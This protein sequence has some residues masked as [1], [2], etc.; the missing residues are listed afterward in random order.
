MAWIEGSSDGFD[1]SGISASRTSANFRLGSLLV[2]VRHDAREQVPQVMLEA[3][4]R[5]PS[6]SHQAV[7]RRRFALRADLKSPARVCGRATA[8]VPATRSLEASRRQ[9]VLHFV[10]IGPTAGHRL[11]RVERTI[12]I[13]GPKD[14][15]RSPERDARGGAADSARRG[16][17]HSWS[18]HYQGQP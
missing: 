10:R 1:L 17:N 14:G 6:A 4:F 16:T 18:A 13:L 9:V 5:A 12:R 15:S 3:S 8:H 11:M 7:G 2:E